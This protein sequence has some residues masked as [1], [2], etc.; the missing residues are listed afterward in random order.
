[1]LDMTPTV[2]T[3]G[4]KAWYVGDPVAEE[5]FRTNYI[6]DPACPSGLRNVRTGKPAGRLVTDVRYGPHNNTRP[7][8]RWEIK[9]TFSGRS[10]CAKVHRVIFFRKHGYWPAIVDHV[11]GD[12]LDNTRLQA[13]SNA[14]NL[15][16]RRKRRKPLNNSSGF[17]GV[18]FDASASTWR[19]EIKMNGMKAHLGCFDNVF[20]AAEV[21]YRARLH[22]FGPGGHMMEDGDLERL[23]EG[24]KGLDPDLVER[25][26]LKALTRPRFVT[27]IMKD[28]QR[29]LASSG[30]VVE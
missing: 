9:T 17:V 2:K 22:A 29:K 8:S 3:H 10:L 14:E 16:K 26:V 21:S 13:L 6:D 5:F 23:A 19:A 1:M 28:K 30:V 11:S 27:A 7:R 20:L 4:K 25:E 24:L 18:Y 15:R 12:P